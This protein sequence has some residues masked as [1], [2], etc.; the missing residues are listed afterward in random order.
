MSRLYRCTRAAL[1]RH[2]CAG[3]DDLQARQG[4]YVP[5]CSA[6]CARRAM[7]V[8]FSRDVGPSAF[9]AHL[10]ADEAPGTAECEGCGGAS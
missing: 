9:T 2:A 10:V 5:A 6:P 7:A 3:R 8:A 1:Y 4:H